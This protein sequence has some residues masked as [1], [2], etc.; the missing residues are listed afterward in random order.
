[1]IPMDQIRDAVR[2]AMSSLSQRTPQPPPGQ[3]QPPTPPPP[4]APAWEYQ[5]AEL[6][7]TEIESIQ[8]G[9]AGGLQG[10]VNRAVKSALDAYT[11]YVG[12]RLEHAQG[13]FAESVR[14]HVVQAAAQ[15]VAASQFMHGPDTRYLFREGIN[16][17]DHGALSARQQYIMSVAQAIGDQNPSWPLDRTLAETER[18]VRGALRLSDRKEGSPPSV[19]ANPATPAGIGGGARQGGPQLSTEQILARSI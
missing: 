13:Q 12:K 16:E 3:P 8:R 11:G 1:V 7:Q 4:S 14:P 15:Q 10:Y 5:G 18:Q 9:D 19:A 17:N 6:T 2:D